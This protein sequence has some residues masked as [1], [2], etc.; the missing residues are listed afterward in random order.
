MKPDDRVAICAERGVEMVIAMFA[1]LKS[2]GAYVPLDSTYPP[3]RLAYMLEDSAPV[4][5]LACGAGAAVAAECANSEMKVLDLLA[6]SEMW[7]D[8]NDDNLLRQA[9]D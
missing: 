5:V 4:V 3:E 1:V 7:R 6:D 2:G 8:L 9:L